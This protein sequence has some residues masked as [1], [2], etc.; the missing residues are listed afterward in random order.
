MKAIKYTGLVVFLI[1]L[2]IFT[3]SVF[4]GNFSFT[5]KELDTFIQE[6]G[7][8]SEIIKEELSK[9]IVT[10]ENLN[11]FQF[12]ER[13]RNAVAKNNKHYNDLIAKYNKEKNWD[14]KGAQYQYRI[15]GKPHTISFQI[16]KKAGSGFVKENAS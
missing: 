16:A 14:K 12:S 2:T 10:E 5:E 3:A 15:D 6:K 11:I 9:A 13:V 1:G 7:Y 8:K 4:T